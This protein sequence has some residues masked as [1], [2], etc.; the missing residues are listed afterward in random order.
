MAT[1]NRHQQRH[2]GGHRQVELTLDLHHDD[3]RQQQLAKSAKDLRSHIVANA[4]HNGEESTDHDARNAERQ[5]NGKETAPG[6][7]AEVP[8]R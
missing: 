7:G 6:S 5:S 8:R 3:L 1:T 4:E 2:G